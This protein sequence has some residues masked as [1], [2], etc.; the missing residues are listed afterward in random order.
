MHVYIMMSYY[1]KYLI[2]DIGGALTVHRDS[3]VQFTVSL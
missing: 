1:G 2:L 3:L